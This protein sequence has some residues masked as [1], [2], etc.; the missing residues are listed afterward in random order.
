MIFILK[1]VLAPTTTCGFLLLWI[2]FVGVTAAHFSITCCGSRKKKKEQISSSPKK[3]DKEKEQQ[4]VEDAPKSNMIEIPSCMLSVQMEV[5]KK[6]ANE[7]KSSS[8]LRKT[9]NYASLRRNSKIK[10][11]ASPTVAKLVEVEKSV[12]N[13][14]EEQKPPPGKIVG[15][16]DRQIRSKPPE[17]LANELSQRHFFDH[18]PQRNKVKVPKHPH[19][20][21]NEQENIIYCSEEANKTRSATTSSLTPERP[22]ESDMRAARGPEAG[23]K[24]DDIN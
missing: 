11:R 16:L 23:T 2:A 13:E 3:E 5:T 24:N 22:D 19:V 7:R 12:I 1:A 6:G 20:K 21:K 14:V 9:D 10:R 17:D 4:V 18:S 8:S 15:S